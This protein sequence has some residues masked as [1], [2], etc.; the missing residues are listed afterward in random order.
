ML[1][2]IINQNI[3]FTNIFL[4]LLF[5]YYNHS[6]YYTMIMTC[7]CIIIAIIDLKTYRIPDVL[8]GFFALVML[9]Y[10]GRQPPSIIL[11][12]LVAATFSFLLFA[13]VW[14]YSHGLGFGDVKYA[15]LLGYL[16]G[17]KRLV[18]AF[19]F[20]AFL[21]VFIYFLGVILFRW[22]KTTK[23]PYAPFLSAG[24]IMAVSINQT[25]TTGIQ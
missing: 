7:F 18:Y 22:P 21:G 16:L 3:K 13:A 5:L 24:A 9:V 2:V 11:T 23:I 20:T 17:P 8:L 6:M 12:R 10:E 15:F 14:Y 25:L 4:I 1:I 19:I